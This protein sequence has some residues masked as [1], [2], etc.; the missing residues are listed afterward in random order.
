MRSK[1]TRTHSRIATELPP[2]VRREIDRLLVEGNA[3]YEEISSYLASKGHDISKS[4]IYRYGRKFLIAYRK[5]RVVQDQS[6]ALVADAGDDAMLLE[7]AA[8]KIFA[9]KI[10]EAQ[11]DGSFS[12]LE[13]PRLV[14]DFA[15]LQSSSIMRERLKAELRKKVT[16]AAEHAV[17]VARS[18]GLTE[19][20]AA[21]IRKKILGIV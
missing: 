11:L 13:L 7:E 15:K 4:A 2:D 12:V 6:R 20:K 1:V 8:A 18:G 10:L 9:Q 16:V 19:E 14:S 3:T 21:E 5:L 17:K